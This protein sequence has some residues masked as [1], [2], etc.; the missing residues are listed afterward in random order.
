M[1]KPKA[2]SFG[3]VT[4]STTARDVNEGSI[5]VTGYEI[6]DKLYESAN[7]LVYRTKAQ[8]GRPKLILKIRKGYYP[9]PEEL[10]RFHQEF[11]I[12]QMLHSPNI[13]RVF[14][15]EKFKN[16]LVLLV[17]DFDGSPVSF[18]TKQSTFSLLESL[19][20]SIKIC[21]GI[22]DVHAQN[23]IHKN[24]NLSNII[25]N[26][27]SNVV[28]II[29]FGISSRLE[30]D[31]TFPGP[32]GFLEGDLFYM[33][34]EQTGRMNRALDYRSDF[35]SLGVTLYELFTGERPFEA[36]DPL[37]MIYCHIAK[38][39]LSPEK[40]NPLIPVVLSQIIL[41]LLAK[42]ADDRYQSTEGIK[43][44]LMECLRQFE[45]VGEIAPFTLAGNDVSPRF[46]LP[47][48]LYGRE[49]DAII[50][51][52][53]FERVCRGEMIFTLVDGYSGVGKSCLVQELY[54]PLAI[55][56]GRYIS[57]KY[58]QYHRNIPYSALTKAF[59]SLCS[60]LLGES[61]NV[62]NQWRQKILDAVGRNGQV[63]IEVIPD[64]E[65]IIG[66]QPEVTA[67][68][69]QAAQNR[70]NQ[71]FQN[72]VAIICRPEE[73]LILFLDDLQWADSASLVLI[74]TIAANPRLHSLHLVGAYRNNEVDA[75]HPFS[76]MLNELEKDGRAIST[77]HLG[78]LPYDSV[79]TL[80]SDTLSLPTD[81]VSEL[82]GM[83]YSKTDG[84]AFF[85][86]EFIKGLH[87]EGLV[88]F[89]HERRRW[90]W[91]LEQIQKRQ[92]TNN[93]LELMAGKISSFPEANKRM[94][95]FAA[96]V[97]NQFDLKTLAIIAEMSDKLAL[98]HLMPAIHRGIVVPKNE[99]YR[100]IGI[101]EVDASDVKFKFQHDRVHQAAYSLISE[102]ERP[103]A[104][105]HIA[106]LLLGSCTETNAAE[107]KLFDI[108]THYDKGC[109]LIDE[110]G[111]QISVATLNLQAGIKAREASAHHAS[112]EFFKIAKEILTEG[113]FD[114]D[115]EL[116]LKVYLNLAKSCYMTGKFDDA[117][118]LY[119]VILRHTRT[120][121]DTV[122]VHLAQMDDYHLRGDFEKAIGIQTQALKLLGENIPIDDNGWKLAIEREL[123]QIP[124]NLGLRSIVDLIHAPEIQS[125]EVSITLKVLMGMWI[126]AYIVS[127][128]SLYQWAAV[129]MT[130]LCLQHG[131]SELAAFAFLQ[132]GNLCISRNQQFET[133]FEYGQLA[134]KMSDRYGNPEIRG[135]VYFMFGLTISNWKKNLSFSTDSFRQSYLSSVEGGDWTYAIYSACNI[136]S[137]LTMSGT[138]CDEVYAEAIKYYE[139]LKDKAANAID[140]FFLPGAFCPLLNLQGKTL[141]RE[142]FNCENFDEENFLKT[143]GQIPLNEGWY[144]PGKIRS[145][146]LFRCFTEGATVIAKTELVAM[147]TR[148]QVR[149]PETYFY[150]GLMLAATH[151]SV[152][153]T[154]TRAHYWSLFEEYLQQMK[155]WADHCPENF[156][157]KYYL[158]EAEKAR[159]GNASLDEV[160][161]KYDKAIVSAKE[162]GFVNNEA[163]SYELKGRFF[164]E[165]GKKEEAFIELKKALQ[166]YRLWGVDS[167]IA[168]LEEEFPELSSRSHKETVTTFQVTGNL[169]S[170]YLDLL[171]VY[172]AARAISSEINLEKLIQNMMAIIMESTGAQRGVLLLERDGKWFIEAEATIGIKRVEVTSGLNLGV[173]FDCAEKIKLPL[174]IVNYV[175]RTQSAVTCSQAVND[176]RFGKDAYIVACQTQSVHCLPL[177]L[178]GKTTGVIYLENKSSSNMFT[179]KRKGIMDLLAGQIAISLENARLY[180]ELEQRVVERT[181]EL[182]GSNKELKKVNLELDSFV[183]TASH[184]LRAPL[185]A[186]S[187]FAS[188]LEEDNEDQL[189]ETG[190]DHL[191]EIRK[192]VGRITRLIDD[193]LMLSRMSRVQNPYENVDMN[194]LVKNA[195]DR[196]EFDFKEKGA[197]FYIPPNLPTVY[198][199]C[200]KVEEVFVNLLDN[201]V[202]FSSKN[203]HV[204]KVEL[205]YRE[206]K[207]EHEFHVADNGIG[208][209]PRFH[210]QIFELFK[211]LH[212]QEEYEGTGAGLSIV[213]R[214]IEDHKGRIWVESELGKGA[215][216]IFTIPKNLERA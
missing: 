89:S 130:N 58:D 28:K 75:S 139:F 156:L 190:R 87:V 4:A 24:I 162:S 207:V 132:Y 123:E 211:R 18:W 78:N 74:K 1:N 70:F 117:D 154:E 103:R 35:Y 129:R 72:F 189:D 187:S 202:K 140:S 146:Y 105:L 84:N 203:N 168:M 16:T 113:A 38:E 210:V 27:D 126:S 164:L 77:I 192:G 59:S 214:I 134:T 42:S 141:S 14:G 26:R 41:K 183:Y 195:E 80:V 30:R 199:D 128:D 67:V 50:L 167:K 135:K 118:R 20:L 11:E 153:N 147:S 62:L 25:W 104:H 144:Y 145:L 107:N 93:V 13:I 208:I 160:L 29:D 8:E 216:F 71:L 32:L 111:E 91:N 133:G 68:D 182:E 119:P 120:T 209:E 92:F 10:V 188:F 33:S 137:N 114:S 21:E 81:A 76:L 56:K 157:H 122:Q 31:L 143:L 180:V 101:T 121:L 19:K 88:E 100:R 193:L 165:K 115:Y 170:D 169:S 2:P 181:K 95:K 138:P 47:A 52:N 97:G 48:K 186:I 184:D 197:E 161:A 177:I 49:E 55:A 39:P 63:L 212:T 37:E 65:K 7:S 9:V 51:A 148:G 136:V 175:I 149:I 85:T 34:P 53:S 124:K 40:I 173:D 172:K 54:R 116:A 205:G 66:P 15:I 112:F 150:S 194:Q 43:A 64:L 57:G 36:E 96:C 22:A 6:T 79:M 98:E 158:L 45:S 166:R 46:H 142:S 206:T 185:R 106:R 178:Q 215:K 201:A 61:T 131:N 179:P 152:A 90:V 82:A 200:I 5:K 155:L 69:P 191:L 109:G 73:P 204:P 44:D 99:S 60:Q 213:K 151:Q 171:T 23:I 12:T 94:L 83:I 108:V 86:M 196:I 110:R 102:A 127:K 198:C 163:L 17:E 176:E 159:I 3:K 174:S 125:P